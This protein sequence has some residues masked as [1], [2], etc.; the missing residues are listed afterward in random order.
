[1]RVAVI[2]PRTEL[3]CMVYAGPQWEIGDQLQWNSKPFDI[4]SVGPT[5]VRDTETGHVFE[6]PPVRIF[7]CA[8]RLTS[9][10]AQLLIVPGDEPT[11]EFFSS[12]IPSDLD[13]RI[14][15]EFTEFHPFFQAFEKTLLNVVSAAFKDDETM[16]LSGNGNVE[17]IKSTAH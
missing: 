3:P 13:E 5:T 2:N 15:F 1:M 11:R 10:F 14:E 6:F 4:S 9:L 12:V 16:L 7:V 8:V 17:I